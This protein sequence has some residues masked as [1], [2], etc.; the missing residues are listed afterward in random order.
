M[1]STSFF[2]YKQSKESTKNHNALILSES[3][4][5]IDQYG[6]YTLSYIELQKLLCIGKNN[7]FALLNSDEFPT[8]TVGGK[9][10]VTVL[11]FVLW[12]LKDVN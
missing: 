6:K 11:A 7:A 1:N 10:S 8:I 4:R 5:I 3:K 2:N 12:T 9:K